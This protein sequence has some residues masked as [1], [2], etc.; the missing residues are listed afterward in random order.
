MLP[1]STILEYGNKVLT[2]F[3]KVQITSDTIFGLTNLGTLYA[4]GLNSYNVA[5]SEISTTEWTVVNT[6][7]IDMVTGKGHIVV[8]KDNKKLY[9]CGSNQY[10][11]L[12]LG[13]NNNVN[14]F[15]EIDVSFIPKKLGEPGSYNDQ[16]WVIDTDG[17]GYV[18]GNGVYNNNGMGSSNR[19]IFTKQEALSSIGTI[20]KITHAIGGTHVLFDKGDLYACGRNVNGNLGLGTLNDI[21]TFTFVRGNV[22]DVFANYYFSAIITSDNTCMMCGV[23]WTSS[24]TAQRNNNLSSYSTFSTNVI[25]VSTTGSPYVNGSDIGQSGVLL[26]LNDNTSKGIGF[27]KNSMLG[28]SNSTGTIATLTDALSTVDSGTGN[29]NFMCTISNGKIYVCGIF[30]NITYSTPTEII[31]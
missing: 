28:T 15:T 21:S 20:K 2:R 10:G 9:S 6:S 7:V 22:K 29:E 30:A 26:T 25:S 18:A 4:I 19:N 5:G 23:G 13:H 16:T 14:T 31:L 1:F 27:N 12:G 11:Q 8:L 24:G 3:V 17:N